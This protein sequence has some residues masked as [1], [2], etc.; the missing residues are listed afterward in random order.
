M[1]ALEFDSRLGEHAT[2]AHAAAADAG[3]SQGDDDAAG[4]GE[5]LDG[6]GPMHVI[7]FGDPLQL[8]IIKQDGHNPYFLAEALGTAGASENGMAQVLNAFGVD[9]PE[10]RTRT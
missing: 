8:P 5:D 4:D 10:G 2:A 9:T 3:E 1:I 7:K 6:W